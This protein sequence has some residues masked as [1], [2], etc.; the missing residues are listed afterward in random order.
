MVL[1]NSWVIDRLRPTYWQT[2]L[3]M[4]MVASCNTG[5][6]ITKDS[7]DLLCILHWQTSS[8][9]LSHLW[10][11]KPETCNNSL[12]VDNYFP[13][14]APCHVSCGIVAHCTRQ[15]S[16]AI[17]ALDYVTLEG[18]SC[19]VQPTPYWVSPNWNPYTSL[20]HWSEDYVKD[21]RIRNR[22]GSDRIGS[23]HRIGRSNF[24]W[25]FAVQ[26]MIP[27]DE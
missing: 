25:L 4:W 11:H 22:I 9:F 27:L 15:S 16:V 12:E 1:R 20:L 23:D 13:Q 19:T 2:N 3:I 10:F 26:Y 7:K 14:R 18:L 5:Q 21:R 6:T 17:S 24:D 8:T